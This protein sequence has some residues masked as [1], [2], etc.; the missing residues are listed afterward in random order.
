MPTGTPPSATLPA[1]TPASTAIDDTISDATTSQSPNTS[2]DGY[3]YT[4]HNPPYAT[5][6]SILIFWPLSAPID[7]ATAGVSTFSFWARTSGIP[8]THILVYGR[9][10]GEVTADES[11][12]WVSLDFPT[13]YLDQ[14]TDNMIEIRTERSGVLQVAADGSPAD[15]GD[16]NA[17]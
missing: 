14:G 7:S 16:K 10:A 5:P 6:R 15:V 12:G 3:V 11:Y 9:D 17:I 8:V 13:S 2:P 1:N 4:G